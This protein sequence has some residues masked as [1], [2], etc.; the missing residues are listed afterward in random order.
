MTLDIVLPLLGLSLLDATSIGTLLVPLWLLTTPG[1]LR[2]HRIV[3]Y[4]ATI[5][6][7]YWA[8]GLASSA[9][10]SGI[11]PVLGALA[12]HD[13]GL[14]AELAA[15]VLLFAWS[16]RFGSTREDADDGKPGRLAR[17]RHRLSTGRGGAGAVAGLALAAGT[18]E[19]ATMLPYLGALSILS[20]ADLSWW[21]VA[22]ALAAYCLVMTAPAWALLAARLAW[23]DRI[24]PRLAAL[25]RRLTRHARSATGWVPAIVGFLLARDAAWRLGLFDALL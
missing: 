20:G 24:V 25:D 3:G 7:L 5:A 9:G 13:V 4:L 11:A 10:M 1:E 2:A 17:W 12:D 14:W 19:L 6:A 22:A 18:V 16:F 21:A 8:V 23:G 15:G